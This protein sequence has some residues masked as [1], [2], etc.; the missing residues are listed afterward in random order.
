MYIYIY[1]SII[2]LYIYIYISYI[3]YIFYICKYIYLS[4]YL[5]I[6]MYIYVYIYI[7]IYI[8]INALGSKHTTFQSKAQYVLWFANFHTDIYFQYILEYILSIYTTFNIAFYQWIWLTVICKHK[9]DN[10][11]NTLN[12]CGVF[13]LNFCHFDYSCN[14]LNKLQ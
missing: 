10:A 8:Y 3:L 6:Y 11:Y 14:V 9:I 7:Y 13:T 2:Y 4:I 5:S 1:I 12:L